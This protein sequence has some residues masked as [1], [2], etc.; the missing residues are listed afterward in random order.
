MSDESVLAML[1][2]LDETKI[3]KNWYDDRGLV[4]GYHSLSIAGQEFKGQRDPK[5]RLAEIDY[6]FNGKRV[7][8]IG[9]SNGG[10]L[11]CLSEKIIFGVGV[12]YNSK[13]IN[14]ANALKM[15]SNANNVHFFC[16]DLDKEDCS[17]LSDFLLGQ[18]VDICLFLNVAMWIKSWEKVFYF[19]SKITE[20]M[21]FEAHG[22]IER[23]SK[24]LEYVRSIYSDV[25]LLSEGS[26]DDSTYSERELYICN[27]RLSDLVNIK[28]ASKESALKKLYLDAFKDD[29]ASTLKP[30]SESQGSIVVEV[31]EKYIVKISRLKHGYRTLSDEKKILDLIRNELSVFIPDYSF[32]G[33][34]YNVVRYNKID[35]IP[36][37]GVVCDGL[38][39]VVKDKLAFSLA[40]IIWSFHKIPLDKIMEL[41]MDFGESVG[42]SL[43]LIR[44]Q[45]INSENALIDEALQDVLSSHETLDISAENL[46]AG[47]FDLH[48]SNI[49]ATPELDRINGII[50]F[51]DFTVGDRHKD[52]S[53]LY[54]IS[55][56][57]AEHVIDVYE[58][59]GDVY[60]DRNRI[61][62]YVSIFYLDLLARFKARKEMDN[63]ENW[64]R[65]YENFREHTLL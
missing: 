24:Q 12:D 64:L 50:D 3:K 2:I 26:A 47:H 36:L 42:A 15:L 62:H 9:C 18:S 14:A 44:T 25:V 63:Y 53:K 65:V 20:T 43:D 59:I 40:N 58:K 41:Q 48:G 51:G 10:M 11:H 54:L 17:F 27:G 49:I 45:L 16:F 60:L 13:C 55:P 56:S 57:F 34:P 37:S 30:C 29:E 6:N 61:R 5:T 22:S 32:G 33:G 39:G 4:A 19:C 28:V 1:R 7:L 23:R 8:D 46:V 52:L 31:N 38:S 35:G 21:I